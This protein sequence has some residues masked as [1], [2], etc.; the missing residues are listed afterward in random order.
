MCWAGFQTNAFFDERF[1]RS[2]PSPRQNAYQKWTQVAQSRWKAS[3]S[4]LPS[5]YKSLFHENFQ[6]HNA[7]EDVCALRRV[8]FESPLRLTEADI[9][10]NNNLKPASFAFE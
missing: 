8:L 10:N 1:L 9:V 3:K 6:A 5:V 2:Q 7:L 4:N